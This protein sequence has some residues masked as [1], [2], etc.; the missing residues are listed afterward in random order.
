[1]HIYIVRHG[2]TMGN[3]RGTLQGQTDI[4]LLDNGIELAHQ[5]GLGL[6]GI[7]FD[8]AVSSPLKR[9]VQTAV[10]VL[11]ASGNSDLELQQDPRIMELHM[12]DYEGHP[13]KTDKPDAEKLIHTF[14]DNPFIFD[15]FPGGESIDE[16][17]SRTQDFLH[18]L[19]GRD[20]H[21]VLVSTHG[22]ALRAMLN[23]LY[24]DPSDFWQGHVPYNCS[25]SIV[26]ATGG[27]LKLLEM[28]KI[29][30]D[31]TLVV[32]RYADY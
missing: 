8:A 21:N 29:Y 20:Y 22:V 30:Y 25:V 15:G 32:D 27:K 14:F 2:E 23:Q 18:E 1:M 31:N 13:I 11:E 26:E 9:A 16:I 24:R 7:R 28:D 6:A 4:E 19:A 17:C 12:G 5:T 10:A 3:V